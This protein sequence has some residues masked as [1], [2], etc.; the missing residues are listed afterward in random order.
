MSPFVILSP[1]D[2]LPPSH[3]GHACPSRDLLL[4]SRASGPLVSH[5]PAVP[6]ACCPLGVKYGDSAVC[7]W[8]PAGKCWLLRTASVLSPGPA[9]LPTCTQTSSSALLPETKPVQQK[10]ADS[11]AVEAARCALPWA[12]S[13]PDH[14]VWGPEGTFPL[15]VLNHSQSGRH[16]NPHACAS[17]SEPAPRPETF[18]SDASAEDA[19]A[20]A[21]PRS[22]T[23]QRSRD[24]GRNWLPHK[25]DLG[26][27]ASSAK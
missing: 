6:L 24:L 21:L 9:S 16:S 20:L 23:R 18:R 13:C 17:E 15:F 12:T 22:V 3:M 11:A 4:E 8:R 2:K 7:P 26:G 19:S 25:S 10:Q 1:T 5:A 27:G 14:T